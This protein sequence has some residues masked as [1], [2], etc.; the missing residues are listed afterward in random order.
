MAKSPKLVRDR[1]PEIIT[2][3][4]RQ[5]EVRVLDANEYIAALNQKLIE[6]LEEYSISEDVAELVDLAE[7]LYS[8]I[9][10]KGIGMQQFE[11]LRLAK[12]HERGGF[13][14]KFL[15]IDADQM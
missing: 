11:R 4:G 6:E 8:L 5:C 13:E 7:V 3:Q 15:L 1:I 10:A 2:S 12:R 14:Q 9:A